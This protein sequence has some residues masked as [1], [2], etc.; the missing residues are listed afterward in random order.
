[1]CARALLHG[2]ERASRT[3]KGRRSA[4]WRTKWSIRFAARA[5]PPQQPRGCGP[6]QTSVRSLRTNLL[7]DRSPSGAPPRLS[8][9]ASRLWLSPVPRFMGGDNRSAPR[10]ASSS[11]TGVV[12]GRA[13]F[14]TARTRYAKPRAGTALA[15]PSGSHP[16]CALRRARWTFLVR[17]AARD[18]EIPPTECIPLI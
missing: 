12:A 17:H 13:G 14:R 16:E 8:P 7:R 10:A 4:E 2:K 18:Q 3:N 9:E 6:S 1:M 5:L 11:Q 15:Q